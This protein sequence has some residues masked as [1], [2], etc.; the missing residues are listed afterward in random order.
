MGADGLGESRVCVLWGGGEDLF[1][2]GGGVGDG[3]WGWREGAEEA[4]EV[5]ARGEDYGW[6]GEGVEGAQDAGDG[7]EEEG[8]EEGG[9]V[10]KCGVEE[11]FQERRP[12]HHIHRR[13][14][15]DKNEL[16]CSSHARG[17]RDTISGKP[18]LKPLALR[19]R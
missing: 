15:G 10:R 12:S 9:G 8:G 14:P 4:E 18:I 13:R 3:E 1:F 7:D 2:G 19:K 5:E 16:I 6:G 17:G 11:C